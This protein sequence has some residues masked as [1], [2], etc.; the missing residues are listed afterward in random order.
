MEHH[1]T[2]RPTSAGDR[3]EVV[4]IA[5]GAS[6]RLHDRTYGRFDAAAA[7]AWTLAKRT[8][9]PLIINIHPGR[10]HEAQA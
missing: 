2:I 9:I 4:E 1:M 6:D 3:F 10:P 8:K 5:S 7:K